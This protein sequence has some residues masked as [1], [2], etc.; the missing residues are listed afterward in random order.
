M[1]ESLDGIVVDVVASGIVNDPAPVA[2]SAATPATE[3]APAAPKSNRA[4]GVKGVTGIAKE[5][6]QAGKTRVEVQ[7]A[8]AEM[9]KAN[10]KSEKAAKDAASVIVYNIFGPVKARNTTPTSEVPPATN[11]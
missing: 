4:K 11:A 8:V 10:G 3:A 1:S 6:K 9:Y 2:E 5:L 7:A